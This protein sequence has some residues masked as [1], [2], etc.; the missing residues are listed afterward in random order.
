MKLFFVSFLSLFVLFVTSCKKD[1]QED[2]GTGTGSTT[3][4]PTELLKDSLYLFTK[5]IYLWQDLIPS[6]AV[7]NP[8]QYTGATD[9]DAATAEMNGIRALQ[10]LDRFSFVTTKEAS[11]G[12]QTGVAVDYGFFIKSAAAD[13]VAPIDSVHWYV[14]YA[15]DKS[16]AGTSGVNRGW[17]INK[18]NN[19]TVG[20]NQAGVDLLNATFF[21][22]TT[23]ASFEFVKPDGSTT[24]L[25]LSK[26]SF[27]SNS[28]LYKNVIPTGGKKVGYFVFKQFFGTP[29]VTEL[30]TVFNYFKTEGINELVVDLRYNPGGSTATQEVLADLIAPAAAN[31]QVMYKYVFNTSL[32]Q[33]NFPL[34]QKKAGYGSTS[35]REENNTEKFANTGGLSLNRVFFIVTGSTASASE[36]LI[37]NLKPY[38]DVKL[39]GDTTY[40]KP[41]GFF[42]VDIYN[43]SIY[44]ISFKTVNSAG[45]ADYYN[46]FAPDKVAPDGLDKSWGDVTEPS[47]ASA[48]KFISTGTFRTTD[49]GEQQYRNQMQKQLE[50]KPL[51]ESLEKN[52]FNGM[53]TEKFK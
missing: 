19:T 24:T 44:P 51:N 2:P 46:G 11:E 35:F 8:R 17:Y 23:S 52:Q 9:I 42:P 21:G 31:N 26:T 40:G 13:L 5:E 20:Y 16:T 37:N 39:I 7:F 22:T 43:Y 28:V 29:S 32:Q 14:Q 48:I 27:T 30:N 45:N 18:I 50:L 1:V 12:L 10:P 33:G 41:V 53:Y 38:M 47:L 3:A 4:T 6:Y 34:L 36:L 49:A 15:F 25:N